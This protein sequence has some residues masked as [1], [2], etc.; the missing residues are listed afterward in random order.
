MGDQGEQ[1]NIEDEPG[2]VATPILYE[3]DPAGDVTL[4]VVNVPQDLPQNLK[5]LKPDFLAGQSPPETTPTSSDKGEKRPL[6]IRASSKHLSLAC[7]YFAR[8][9]ASG[10]S[11]GIELQSKGMIELQIL[12]VNGLAFLLLI[13]II[14][15]KPRLVPRKVSKETLTDFAVL[16]DYY[17]CHDAVEVFSEMWIKAIKDVKETAALASLHW[18]LISW[19]FKHKPKFKEATKEFVGTWS[20]HISSL[21]LPIPAIILAKMN[22]QRIGFLQQFIDGLHKE[23]EAIALGCLMRNNSGTDKIDLCTYTVLGAF[24]KAMMDLKVLSPKPISPFVGIQILKIVVDFHRMRDSPHVD[25]SKYSPHNSCRLSCRRAALLARHP[26]PEG[27][28]L[29]KFDS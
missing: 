9:F 1:S 24:T 2:K 22:E 12:H 10:F 5:D 19:V 29:D 28:D 6:H 27:L 15:C 8:M 23:H 4:V 3:L 26:L 14:H 25:D 16:V 21:G 17:Q 7:G 18:V 11:E 20:S 13:L